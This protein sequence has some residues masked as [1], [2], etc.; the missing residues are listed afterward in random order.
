MGFL[1]RILVAPLER[2]IASDVRLRI[3]QRK[4]QNRFQEG[5]LEGLLEAAIEIW[6]CWKIS[7]MRRE[8]IRAI[9]EQSRLCSACGLFSSLFLSWKAMRILSCPYRCI[10][11][12]QVSK[13]PETCLKSRI[14]LLDLSS[15]PKDT[16]KP[17]RRSRFL[18]QR[19]LS[20][21]A[22]MINHH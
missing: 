11:L 21:I 10:E 6:E 14:L 18:A 20:L 9:N 16:V 15:I 17:N 2:A 13:A 1:R 22:S 8:V 5:V 19:Q 12:R 7:W 4:V 3:G